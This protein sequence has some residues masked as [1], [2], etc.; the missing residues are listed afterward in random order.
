MNA[1]WMILDTPHGAVPIPTTTLKCPLCGH[2]LVIHDFNP[3]YHPKEGFQHCD[4][5]VKCINCGLW[6]TFGIPLSKEEYDKLNESPL[7][8]KTLRHK[9]LFPEFD[10]LFTQEEKQIIIDRLTKLGYW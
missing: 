3:V 4:V 5:H 9:L 1:K 10:K 6:L 8:I 7:K 2:K